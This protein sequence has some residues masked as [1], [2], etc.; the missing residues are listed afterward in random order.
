MGEQTTPSHQVNLQNM[1]CCC[2]NY[3]ALGRWEFYV[4]SSFIQMYNHF[5]F[6]TK[7]NSSWN[8]PTNTSKTT[9]LYCRHIKI[10]ILSSSVHCTEQLNGKSN[11]WLLRYLP[12]NVILKIQDYSLRLNPQPTGASW[13][14]VTDIRRSSGTVK[15]IKWGVCREEWDATENIIPLLKIC[16]PLGLQNV[17]L[18]IKGWF[19]HQ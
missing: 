18:A 3:S 10:P 5:A 17:C 12:Y 13:D 4:K 11:L 6:M 7:C 15:G 2:T 8:P 19:F 16:E 9:F 14:F 1:I